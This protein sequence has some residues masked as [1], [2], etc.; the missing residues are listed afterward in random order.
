MLVRTRVVHQRIDWSGQPAILDTAAQL[1]L[2]ASLSACGGHT[3]SC[4]RSQPVQA[5]RAAGRRLALRRARRPAGTWQGSFGFS[6]C[7]G[8]NSRLVAKEG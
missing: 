8:P 4:G 3:S 2:G 6:V 5:V 7:T 1:S